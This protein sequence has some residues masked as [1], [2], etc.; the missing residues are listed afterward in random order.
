MA[1]TYEYLGK[2]VI[3]LGKKRSFMWEDRLRNQESRL[4]LQTADLEKKPCL[5]EF[6]YTHACWAGEPLAGQPTYAQGPSSF[7]HP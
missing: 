4:T 2:Q 5:V 7:L 6:Y 3:L 1:A